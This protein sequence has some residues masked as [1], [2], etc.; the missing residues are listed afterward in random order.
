MR[1]RVLQCP[2]CGAP[3][4][5]RAALVKVVCEYCKSE[6]VL[7]RYVVKAS[8]YHGALIDYLTID[9]ANK[10]EVAGV[11]YRLRGRL[12]V[13]HSSD[14]LLTERATR[15]SERVIIKVLRA[16]EDRA[17][18]EHEQAVLR[19]LERS[20]ELGYDYS[21]TLLPQRVAFGQGLRTSETPALSAVFRE[22]TGFRVHPV[23]CAAR[24]SRRLRPASFGL[25]LASDPGFARLGAQERQGS[26]GGI[27]RARFAQCAGPRR[28]PSWL[29]VRCAGRRVTALGRGDGSA[30]RVPQTPVGRRLA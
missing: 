18:F 20:T 27:A 5:K 2:R 24:F 1:L 8:E 14:V 4:P 30:W 22:P 6:V 21:V 7:D 23:G 29:G 3:L 25:D 16:A 13:G 12:A 11:P 10:F 19:D 28:A 17:L 26:R 9:D 15:L